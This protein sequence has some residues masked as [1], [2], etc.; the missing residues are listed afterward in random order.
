MSPFVGHFAVFSVSR[1]GTKVR[2]WPGSTQQW[3]GHGSPR[4]GNPSP[5]SSKQL[6]ALTCRKLNFY[7]PKGCRDTH[8]E[9]C[10]LH[11]EEKGWVKPQ[12]SSRKLECIAQWESIF[13]GVYDLGEEA[14]YKGA[15]EGL[16]VTG[17]MKH[18]GRRA[19]AGSNTTVAATASFCRPPPL[20][21][22][23]DFQTA[24]GTMALDQSR[25][26]SY[27]YP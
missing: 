19:P 27:L 12:R 4:Q 20:R 3:H 22:A 18:L 17:P 2:G 9:L 23:A 1:S 5:S 15:G 10:F 14:S 6:I 24:E 25:M 11:W 21:P 16:T 26:L 13:E 7:G 8:W